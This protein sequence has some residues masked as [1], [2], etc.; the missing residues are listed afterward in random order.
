[1]T[2]GHQNLAGLFTFGIQN[3]GT[4]FTLGL[5]LLLHGDLNFTG[6]QDVFQLYTLYLD[7]P[8]IRCFVQN[9]SDT[10]IDLITGSQGVIQFQFTDDITQCRSAEGFNRH[11]RT[12]NAVSI[13]LGIRDL[14]VNNGI[15]L[16]G[17]VITGNNG[18]RF[19]VHNLLLQGYL[20]GDSVHE[21]YFHVNTGMPGRVVNAETL[22]NKGI[23]LRYDLD[24]GNNN[25]YDQGQHNNQTNQEG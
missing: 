9:F 3:S 19:K 10:L 22:N 23:G 16:H 7:T 1:M 15:N 5:H 13:Q 25:Q 17:Y 4:A 21:R 11:D 6:R 20:A 8:G 24:I 18:L 2:F 14:I 12:L